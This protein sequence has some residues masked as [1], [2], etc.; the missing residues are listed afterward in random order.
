MAS[1]ADARQVEIDRAAQARAEAE[2][3]FAKARDEELR[4]HAD[5]HQSRV[6]AFQRFAAEAYREPVAAYSANPSRPH[7]AA[8]REALLAVE[9][10]A[11]RSIGQQLE[12]PRGVGAEL[13]TA[14][15]DIKV[16]VSPES[17]SRLSRWENY[18]IGNSG[19]SYGQAVRALRSGDLVEA[20]SDLAAVEIGIEKIAKMGS[21]G[22]GD[23][24][25]R[26]QIFRFGGSVTAIDAALLA[27]ELAGF[28]RV[29]GTVED[30]QRFHGAFNQALESK[31]PSES[32]ENVV[33]RVRAGLAAAATKVIDAID[34]PPPPRKPKARVSDAEH[35][36][37]VKPPFAGFV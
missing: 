11:E 21:P 3:A 31:E 35:P 29:N 6:R 8:L 36:D 23:P 10:E 9:A 25:T 13:L 2:T 17:A 5:E 28:D 16:A 15:A 18:G 26:W 32:I 34:P 30:R 27:E 37:D 14:L 22:G 24:A 4:Q 12:G 19:T 20:T 1:I 7:V 33:S